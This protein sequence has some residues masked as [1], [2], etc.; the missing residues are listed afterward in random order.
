MATL[1]KRGDKYF[2]KKKTFMNEAVKMGM[3]VES[4][5]HP[6]FDEKTIKQLV[7]DHL[8]EDPEYYEE[9]EKDEEE[10]ETEEK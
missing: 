2:K 5:E 10:E 9:E 8:K 6:E 4:K 3:E 1:I 7:Q